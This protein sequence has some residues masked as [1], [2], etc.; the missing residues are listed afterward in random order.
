MAMNSPS[1]PIEATRN[2]SMMAAVMAAHDR[3][4]AHNALDEREL[5]RLLQEQLRLEQREAKH[6]KNR[7]G[8]FHRLLNRLPFG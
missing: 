1:S 4:K 8:V 2:A 5:D 6:A 3:E 7:R